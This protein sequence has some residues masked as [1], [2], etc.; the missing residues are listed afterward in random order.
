[1]LNHPKEYEAVE[2]NNIE[3]KAEEIVKM[4]KG[5]TEQINSGFMTCYE[6]KI[7]KAKNH[8]KSFRN[9]EEMEIELDEAKLEME[10]KI[11]CLIETIDNVMTFDSEEDDDQKNAKKPGFF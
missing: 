6:R 2:M 7:L 4:R 1:M 3:K 10:A 11:K 5:T 8:I 9:F